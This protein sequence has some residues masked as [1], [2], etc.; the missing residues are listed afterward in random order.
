MCTVAGSERLGLGVLILWSSRRG[1]PW[2]RQHVA[3][4][5]RGTEHSTI[6]TRSLCFLEHHPKQIL[7]KKVSLMS[8]LSSKP[9]SSFA[10]GFLRLCASTWSALLG[11]SCRSPL[12]LSG[13]CPQSKGNT[14]MNTRS[15]C[16]SSD[17]LV[18]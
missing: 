11:G 18:S 15:S 2:V 1:F 3:I 9:S 17:S 13:S 8:I 7:Q 4:F 12:H 6:S 10:V 5:E 16:H 14:C